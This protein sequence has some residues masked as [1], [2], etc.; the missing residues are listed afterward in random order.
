M[1]PG[2]FRTDHFVLCEYI[3]PLATE[4]CVV[5]CRRQ[6]IGNVPLI[7]DPITAILWL[8]V[9]G[10]ANDTVN[11]RILLHQRHIITTRA[12]SCRHSGCYPV[13]A[14]IAGINAV[15]LVDQR[16]VFMLLSTERPAH[17]FGTIHDAAALIV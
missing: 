7:P 2:A 13:R 6:G 11:G 12:V 4:D 16:L 9:N 15:V 14:S 8:T 5:I 1:L 17:V 10:I 3:H